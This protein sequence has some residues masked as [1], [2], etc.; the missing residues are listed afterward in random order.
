MQ[1]YSRIFNVQSGLDAL[2]YSID[3]FSMDMGMVVCIA[4]FFRIVAYV[5]LE[6]S[7]MTTLG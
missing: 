7:K 4:V 5:S 3:N 6:V 2:N 1:Q